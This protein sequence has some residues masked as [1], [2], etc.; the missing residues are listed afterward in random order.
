MTKK[1][2]DALAKWAREEKARADNPKPEMH[3]P[4]ADDETLEGKRK[5][6]FKDYASIPIMLMS[7]REYAERKAV[8]TQDIRLMMTSMIKAHN[9]KQ[10]KGNGSSSFNY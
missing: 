8:S 6:V 1:V 3:P 5:H 9:L 10:G 7:E 2:R 4:S